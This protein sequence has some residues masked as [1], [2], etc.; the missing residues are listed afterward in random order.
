M[1]QVKRGKPIEPN[2]PE[3]PF[4][5]QV[6]KW[7]KSMEDLTSGCTGCYRLGCIFPIVFLILCYIIG[8][9]MS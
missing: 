9:F 3:D 8:C 4:E 7:S 6:D 2:K 1:P 5:T